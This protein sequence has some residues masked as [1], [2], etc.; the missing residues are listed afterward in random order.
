MT[1]GKG[2]GAEKP[3]PEILETLRGVSCATLWGILGDAYHMKHI[4]PLFGDCKVV[5]PA[6]TIKYAEIDPTIEHEK[7]MREIGRFP[8]PMYPLFDALQPGDV[9]VGAALG[10]DEAG[11]FGDC[12][13]TA[14]KAR[15]AAALVS[16]ASVRDS[17]GIRELDIPVFTRAPATPLSSRGGGV[18]PIEQNVTVICD[19]V[20]VRPGDIVVGD[21]DGIVVVPREWAEEVTRKAEARE[22]LEEVSRRLLLE[23]KPLRECYPRLKMEYVKQY[24]LEEYWE[25]VYP[26]N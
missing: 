2:S 25:I 6:A 10:H 17:S 5:G 3:I 22:K 13:A 24:G 9:V 8:N 11:I 14:F 12:Y 18:F 16:D 7:M 21:G 4:N 1:M 26:G 20:T 19:G 23:G 15:G